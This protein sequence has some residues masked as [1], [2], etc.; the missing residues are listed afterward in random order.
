MVR[1]LADVAGFAHP[2]Q[3]FMETEQDLKRLSR[4]IC[5]RLTPGEEMPFLGALVAASPLDHAVHD[6]F[7]RI[8]GIDSYLGHGP[9]HM[10]FDLS[11]YLGNGF[12]SVYPSQ[13]LRQD[14]LPAVPVFHL[15]GGVD[16]LTRDEVGDDLPA[17]D[18]PNSLDE[19]IERDG[20]FCLKVKLQGRDLD[21]D[22]D[23]MLQVSRIYHEVREG[24]RKDL[25]AAPLL[26]ADTN[27]QCETP[28]VHDRVPP[29]RPRA[30]APG[31]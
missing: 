31:L 15:V 12:R 26:T 1:L 27:E 3:I 20:V 30:G 24:V 17:D 21:W 14:Y 18:I 6:A 8:N 10:D 7:G 28:E 25:P 23:R 22:V 11:R 13:F 5:R 16:L 19:W 29:H 4:D 9:E 2:I